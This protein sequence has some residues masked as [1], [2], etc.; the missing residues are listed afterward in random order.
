[1][2]RGR[3]VVLDRI[4]GATRERVSYLPGEFS[5]RFTDKPR[6]LAGAIH[7]VRGKNAIIAELKCTSPTSGPFRPSFYPVPLATDLIGGGCIGLSVLTEPTFFGGSIST[8]KQVR[9]ISPVPVLRKDFIIDERQVYETRAMGADA[10]LLIAGILKDQLPLYVNLSLTLGLEPLVEVH[11]LTDVKRAHTTEATLIGINNRN[12]DTMDIDL[13]TTLRLSP[14]LAG[15]DT[16]IISMSGIQTPEDI[17]HLKGYCHAF[18]I[19][20]AL[21]RSSHPTE[22]LEG[23][24]SA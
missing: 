20:S 10:I 9:R 21:M 24:V 15:K 8:L 3:V 5:G 4:L 13:E 23:F 17:R 2:K 22:T 12:L 16:T 19:G 11:T 1:M 6:S 14:H 7:S 18:L